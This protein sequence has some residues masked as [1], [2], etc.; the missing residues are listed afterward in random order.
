VPGYP[1]VTPP[2]EKGLFVKE[3]QGVS[4][5]YY[6]KAKVIIL[7]LGDIVELVVM[8]KKGGKN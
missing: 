8:P 5:S 2:P 6:T 7:A 3:G 1:A 4:R